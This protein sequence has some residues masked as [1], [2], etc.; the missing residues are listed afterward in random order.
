[1]EDFILLTAHIS[2]PDFSFVDNVEGRG[3][4]AVGHGIEPSNEM[5]Y[6]TPLAE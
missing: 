2:G 5:S 6:T 4:N 1:M 3:S